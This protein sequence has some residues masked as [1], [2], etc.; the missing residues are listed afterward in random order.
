[1]LP[2]RDGMVCARTLSPL[3]A[4]LR[5]TVQRAFFGVAAAEDMRVVAARGLERAEA[6]LKLAE[7]RRAAGAVPQ[8][9]VVRMQA[10]VAS[11]RLDVITVESRAR[12]ARGR[13]N[14]AIGRAA[15]S[16]VEIAASFSP[17]TETI[18]VEAATS[19]ALNLRPE[20]ISARGRTPL[21]PPYGPRVRRARRTFG[22]TEASA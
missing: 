9:D 12:I 14:A 22:P 13:L 16:P 4:D 5:L 19:N 1:M 17:P 15:S 7:A 21:V 6:G 20:I 2:L 11:A 18:D 8:A 3:R 10:E